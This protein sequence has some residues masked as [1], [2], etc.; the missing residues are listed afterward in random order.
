[1]FNCRGTFGATVTMAGVYVDAYGTGERR[2]RPD[3]LFSYDDQL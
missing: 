3:E 2:V 1:M